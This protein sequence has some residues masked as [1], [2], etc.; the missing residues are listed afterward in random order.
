MHS[1]RDSGDIIGSTKMAS[2][3]LPPLILVLALLCASCGGQ[4]SVAV[5]PAQPAG[6]ALAWPD[7]P[8][9]GTPG[10][11]PVYR[12]ASGAVAIDGAQY[13]SQSG[14][15]NRADNV[16]PNSF[17][18]IPGGGNWRL[19]YARYSLP[20]LD[21]QRPVS[22]DLRVSSTPLLPG[23]TYNLPLSYYVGV[24]DYTIN[25][26]HWFGPYTETRTRVTLNDQSTDQL[27]RCVSSTAAGDVL[28]IIIATVA[29]KEFSTRENPV[30]VT[31]VRVE[32]LTVNTSGTNYPDYHATRPHYAPINAIG[33]P[34]GKGPSMLDRRLYVQLTWEHQIDQ[35]GA[36]FAAHSYDIYRQGP[37]DQ[38]A[39]LIGSVPAPTEEYIDPVDN[40]S[41]IPEPVPGT[42][43]SYFL[44]ANNAAGNTPLDKTVYT[45]P[46][47]LPVV[48]TGYDIRAAGAAGGT[49]V[50]SDIFAGEEQAF[51]IANQAL[52][53]TLNSV[54]GT[55]NGEAFNASILPGSMTQAD[56][57]TIKLAVT[58]ALA[59]TFTNEGDTP[60]GLTTP[61][62]VPDIAYSGTGNPGSGRVSPDNFPASDY[63]EPEGVCRTT[64]AVGM[65]TC[66]NPDIEI[67]VPDPVCGYLGFD[68]APDRAAPVI[69][70][71]YDD[72][73]C[74]SRLTY[75]EPGPG[76]TTV[77]FKMT[78]WGATGASMPANG[79]KCK[80]Q[81]L[82][83][84]GN[85][86]PYA[87][88]DI[89]WYKGVGHDPGAGEFYFYHS[90]YPLDID[91]FVGKVPGAS[92]VQGASYAFRFYDGATWSSI[93]LPSM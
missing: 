65:I 68:L 69:Q 82:R 88:I 45:V 34:N 3:V 73:A 6:A 48:I 61:W 44:R 78:S 25:S 8:G 91:V 67:A 1:T 66:G 51:V 29:G 50:C 30:G 7:F 86:P 36:N 15:Y 81:L 70:G 39:V 37:D 79:A 75:L 41:G 19:A 87:P 24:S 16:V 17:D 22:L 35:Y 5:V 63:P 60:A 58:A 9:D 90:I 28:Q 85:K 84:T 89:T 4:D 49:G 18:I 20:G 43:Y 71:L 53:M 77:Y 23:Q 13:V 74:T 59:W 92:L 11:P 54:R 31:A 10:S 64:L 12:I 2:G 76:V 14:L 38:Q 56:Y 52:K 93:Y 26:W 42:T 47:N 33:T 72:L 46:K 83:I 55:W 57:N 62:F 27:D 40:S 21:T 32:T 80:L